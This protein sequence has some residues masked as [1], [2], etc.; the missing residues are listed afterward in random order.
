MDASVQESEEKEKKKGREERN[1]GEKEREEGREGREKEEKEGKRERKE[2]K[3][4]GFI[5][6]RR[7]DAEF[8]FFFLRSTRYTFSGEIPFQGRETPSRVV[9]S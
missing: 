1:K 7:G 6:F 2:E 5:C 4:R 3:R 9:V 8:F